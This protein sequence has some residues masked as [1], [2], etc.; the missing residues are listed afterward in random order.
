MNPNDRRVSAVFRPAVRLMEQLQYRQKLLLVGFMFVC[1]AG[2]LLFALIGQ[3]TAERARLIRE[4]DGNA[5]IA[6]VSR[7]VRLI[8][9]HR[10]MSAAVVGGNLEFVSALAQKDLE[11]DA[12]I[13]QLFSTLAGAEPLQSKLTDLEKAWSA[14][15]DQ[16][17]GWSVSQNFAQH[18]QL[19][20]RLLD[21]QI[22][23]A[24]NHGMFLDGEVNTRYLV[25]ITV[26]RLPALLENLGKIRAYGTGILADRQI[27]QE[28][29]FE[30]LY[31]I[32]DFQ[33]SMHVMQAQLLRIRESSPAHDAQLQHAGEVIQQAAADFTQVATDQT[34]N[35]LFS[36]TP[37][38]FFATLTQSIDTIYAELFGTFHASFDQLLHERQKRQQ[39]EMVVTIALTGAFLL[40]I[41]YLAI[42]IYVSVLGN[43]RG[44][45]TAMRKFA[46]GDFGQR[47]QLDTRDEMQWI[48]SQ[49]NEMAG[50]I[51]MLLS[52]R[53]KALT[54]LVA[55]NDQL[56]M[57]ARVF[58]E[59][60]EG[61]ALT[62][63]RGV[64]Q[65]VNPAFCSITGYTEVE[66]IGQPHSI[67]RSNR[68]SDDFFRDMW[69]NLA[70]TGTW[71]GEI[72][73]QR[74]GG[75]EYAEM[76]SISAL[77]DE[78]GAVNQY[79]GIFSDITEV[80]LYQ[81]K[82]ERQAHYDEL[83]GLP[84]RSLLADRL[85]QAVA[86]AR[87]NATTVAVV[88]LD[89]DGFK[90]INDTYGHD[91]GDKVL[92]ETGKRLMGALRNADTVAR[93]GGD[94]FVMVLA[95]VSSNDDCVRTLSR[96]LDKICRPIAF[97]QNQFGSVTGSIGYTLF[98]DDDVQPDG[99]LR[100]ADMAMYSSKEAGKNRVTRFDV[101]LDHRQRGFA[102]AIL[103]LEKG[104]QRSEF[105]LYVQPKI[106]LQTGHVVGAEALIRWI[107]PIRGLIPPAEFLPLIAD[108][109]ALSMAFDDWVLKEGVRILAAWQSVGFD[110]PLSLNMSPFQ[111][112]S[113]DFAE[114]VVTALASEPSLSTRHLEI[115]I[116]ETSALD[117]LASAVELIAKCRATGIRFAL[118]DFGTGYSTLTYL[119]QM[120]VD[121]LKI[122]RTFI[123]DMGQ[124]AAS[125][126]IVKGVV[127]MAAAFDCEVVAEG[128]EHWSQAQELLK[129]NCF[130]IQGYV[131]AAPMPAQALPA[132]SA[133][134]QLPDLQG[135]LP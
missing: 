15:L 51:A 78:I 80:K 97:G 57:A 50:K 76:L 112:Q 113:V 60:R 98:P 24:D 71:R 89:L 115:E 94:E 17:R 118:D 53:Q 33:S 108:K 47:V 28:R 75:E 130:T 45:T 61:I 77:R 19:I 99:L 72:W 63:A 101:N 25:D 7:T 40:V 88:A 46:A 92:N 64:I 70:L 95:D 96:V 90:A 31:L 6:Q 123:S 20:G 58:H 84:N 119:K 67:L 81:E 120:A 134:F 42:G 3:F 1:A 59:S 11:A 18:N 4:H 34:L 111:F 44:L 122:D 109:K 27:S 133:A 127:A 35:A 117:D 12:A 116:L 124:A 37:E 104:L 121:T 103:R 16:G 82:L 107:H 66:V 87:R 131:V 91:A 26:T 69:C 36:M 83:T 21:L 68:Q 128:V 52:E 39:R 73:N 43:I 30:L 135:V 56:A 54:D 79:V 93:I 102:D 105:Q 126:A 85:A 74:K 110:I 29:R 114:K 55:I 38:A 132:W 22:H 125:K 62:D 23:L 49:F 100:H 13:R 32:A 8:Q 41:M 2:V 86:S 106:N 9:Q 14:I 129:M 65:K 10:G 5:L 48:G